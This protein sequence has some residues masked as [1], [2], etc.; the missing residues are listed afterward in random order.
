MRFF[1]IVTN[2]GIDP[3]SLANELDRFHEQHQVQREEP[4][5]IYQSDPNSGVV[6]CWGSVRS[7]RVILLPDS[8]YMA[9]DYVSTL[10]VAEPSGEFGHQPT[11][12]NMSDILE[13]TMKGADI[14]TLSCSG[15]PV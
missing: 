8:E 10:L 1:G 2:P 12:E 11:F 3:F 15:C 14:V 13:S 7:A 6:A 5:L 4:F 9:R